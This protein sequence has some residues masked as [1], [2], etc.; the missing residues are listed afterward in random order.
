MNVYEVYCLLSLLLLQN[1]TVGV[2]VG[3]DKNYYSVIVIFG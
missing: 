2:E 1:T 3:D